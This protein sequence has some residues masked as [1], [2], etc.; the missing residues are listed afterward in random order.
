[1][2]GLYSNSIFPS[3][4]GLP[5]TSAT[6]GFLC[7]SQWIT[8]A[9]LS[10]VGIRMGDHLSNRVRLFPTSLRLREVN[11]KRRLTCCQNGE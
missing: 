11:V 2:N 10:V 5:Y 8:E 9:T 6:L 1:M 4:L 7:T 3:R